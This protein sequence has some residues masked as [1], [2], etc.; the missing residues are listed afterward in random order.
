M[1]DLHTFAEAR[2]NRLIAPARVEGTLGG[3]IHGIVY[4]SSEGTAVKV[5]ERNADFE[6][7]L[8]VYERLREFRV[9]RIGRFEVPQLLR[10]GTEVHAIEMTTVKPPF[11]LDFAHSLLDQEPDFSPEVWEQWRCDSME[12]F[13]EHWPQA[14]A[15]FDELRRKYGIWHLDLSPRNV[16]F[17]GGR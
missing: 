8:A 17:G 9:S 3:G 16:H 12:H 6:Q 4:L 2:A 10:H 7:E 14:A 15:V 1:S 5:Y 11:V 13:G